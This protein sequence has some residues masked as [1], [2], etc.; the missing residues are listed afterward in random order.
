MEVILREEIEKLGRCGDVVKVADGYA[1][2]F[3]LPKRM[4]VAATESN[5]KIVDQEKQAHLRRDAKEVADAQ[6]LARLMGNVSVTISQKAGE[7]DH[8]FG[9]VTSGDIAA[10]LEKQGYTIDRKK[11]HLDEPIKQLGEFK[12]AVRLH[13]DV[14]VEVPVNVV[15]EEA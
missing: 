5:K 1:R 6:E 4:A 9:S 11:V 2:N 14:T 15:R 3:L 8:L 7:N 10:A 12:A 13:R